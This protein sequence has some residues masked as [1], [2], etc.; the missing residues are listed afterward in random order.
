MDSFEQQFS[1]HSVHNVLSQLKAVLDEP[2]KHDLD[3]DAIKYVDRLRQA[4]AFISGRLDIASPVLATAAQLDRI[5]KPIQACLNELNQFEGNGNTG[6]LANASNQL[7]GAL[8]SATTLVSLEQPNPQV[9]AADAVGF[10]ELAENVIESLRDDVTK[11]ASESESVSNALQQITGSIEEQ[12]QHL[13]SLD[14]Q[15]SSKLGELQSSFAS[16]Q[17]ARQST[18]D[19]LIEEFTKGNSEKLEELHASTDE[20][21]EYIEKKRKDAERIVHLIG[22]IGITGNFR[23]AA[24][25]EGRLANIFR[26]IA[27]LCFLCMVGVIL[28]M[29]FISLHEQFDIWLAVFRFAIGFAFLVPGVYAARESSKH[30][31]LENRNR[32]AELEL[33]SIDNYLDSLP[34]EKRDE[35]K[36]E[37]S[38]KYFGGDGED[39]EIDGEATTKSLI[40][41][42]SAA[43]KALGTK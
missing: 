12:K 7:D 5:Q 36:S 17:N 8:T 2:S 29:G 18:F 1:G 35:I 13:A 39:V 4:R 19:S 11:V 14:T 31:R 38:V 21:I 42:L 41:L 24:T 33:A 34:K 6:H 23:G 15:I 32:K 43:I 20:K 28:Y 3:E 10:K 25:R 40:D 27:L 22:N 9:K 26:I 30:R 16:A 37:L